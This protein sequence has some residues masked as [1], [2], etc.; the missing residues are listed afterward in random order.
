M[1]PYRRIIPDWQ[2]IIDSAYPLD[3]PVREILLRH[4]HQVADLAIAL[5]KRKGFEHDPKQIEAAAMLH[6]IGIIHTNAPGIDCHGD[7]PYICHGMIGAD[8]LRGLGLNE[9]YPRVCERHTGAGFTQ[10]EVK[11]FGLPIPPE[12]SAT[13]RTLIEMLICYAD[14]FFSKSNGFKQKTVAELQDKFK[15]YS[16]LQLQKFNRMLERFGDPA[17]L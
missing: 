13:P 14:C 9:M 1:E 2:A 16:E 10:A 8:M 11:H 7:A 3:R 4:S 17:D 5:A 12:R 15:S 6:D